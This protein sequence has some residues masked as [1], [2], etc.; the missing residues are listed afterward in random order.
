MA[1]DEMTLEL[2]S[3]MTRFAHDFSHLSLMLRSNEVM[4]AQPASSNEGTS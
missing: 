1:D 2:R 3:S 4:P